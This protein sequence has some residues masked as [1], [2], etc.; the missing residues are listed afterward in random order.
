[1]NDGRTFSSLVAAVVS[2]AALLASGVVSISVT[3]EQIIG[4]VASIVGAGFLLAVKEWVKA[5][6]EK[7]RKIM[8][9]LREQ[10]EKQARFEREVSHFMGQVQAR[11]GLHRYDSDPEIRVQ[12]HRDAHS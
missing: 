2:G 3:P 5:Q 1:M 9:T 11:L 12:E 4:W 6:K 8:D 10:S 7:D